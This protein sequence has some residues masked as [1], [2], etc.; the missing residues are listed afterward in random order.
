MS[1]S[2]LHSALNAIREVETVKSVLFEGGEPFLFYP[3]LLS[4][5]REAN[6]LKFLT[7][8]LSN[9]YWATSVEN[10]KEFLIPIRDVGLDHLQLSSDYYHGIASEPTRVS[11]AIKAARQVGIS[12]GVSSALG[13]TPAE[14]S[15]PKA[16]FGGAKRERWNV[17]CRGRASTLETR[18]C[19][20]QCDSLV[21]CPYKN[22]ADPQ[23]SYSLA[24]PGRVHWDPYGYVYVC[25]GLA[26]GNANITPLYKI[27]NEYDPERHPI[28]GP[29]LRGGPK[30]LV[31]DFHLPH[32]HVYADA[33]HLCYDARSRLRKEFPGLLAPAQVYGVE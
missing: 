28:I 12:V 32:D 9:G 22:L 14:C 33:C 8:V 23:G 26:I 16:N 29:L 27:I 24:E 6:Y 10:A 20:K 2:Q 18:V 7:C 25:Q 31:D 15:D 11:N 17:M 30:A 4:G 13:F 1:L 3:I 19:D 5:V 21:E